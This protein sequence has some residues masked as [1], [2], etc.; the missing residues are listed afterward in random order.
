MAKSTPP[1]PRRPNLPTLL[2]WLRLVQQSGCQ[3]LFRDASS[4]GE[5]ILQRVD[6]RDTD[7]PLS[8]SLNS[9][10]PHTP[11]NKKGAPVK[12]RQVIWDKI[13]RRSVSYACNPFPGAG[14][15]ISDIPLYD[16]TW[17]PLIPKGF[18]GASTRGPGST[19]STRTRCY[20]RSRFTGRAVAP[21]TRLPRGCRSCRRVIRHLDGFL[22]SQGCH[23]WTTTCARHPPPWRA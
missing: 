6:A 2:R 16:F 22:R 20:T 14:S 1:S 15:L 9:K 23:S 13:N 4:A 19:S 10:R 21:F 12:A 7:A 8:S 5:H 18:A 3:V 11:R 17:H